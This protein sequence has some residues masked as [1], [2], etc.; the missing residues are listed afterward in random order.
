MRAPAAKVRAV[1]RLVVAV[2]A[3]AVAPEA[4]DTQQVPEAQLQQDQGVDDADVA[5]DRVPRRH[6]RD[7]RQEDGVGIERLA[8][9]VLAP[10]EVV[11][12]PRREPRQV[13]AI[14]HPH[15]VEVAV[16]RD[17]ASVLRSCCPFAFR[18]DVGHDAE[19]G[20]ARWER[21]HQDPE[22]RDVDD[23]PPSQQV[24]SRHPD[25]VRRLNEVDIEAVWRTRPHLAS[26]KFCSRISPWPGRW[27]LELGRCG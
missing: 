25:L 14:S 7:G 17:A 15:A 6:D 21:Q 27:N 18:D 9:L 4:H 10:Q 24:G 23:V 20:T 3:R 11:A 19:A 12:E 5:R 13:D 16:S 8:D 22:D 1:A 2:D 26:S